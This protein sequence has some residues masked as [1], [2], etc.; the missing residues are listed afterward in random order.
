MHSFWQWDCW[1]HHFF[2]SSSLAFRQFIQ[3]NVGDSSSAASAPAPAASSGYEPEQPALAVFPVSW[4]ILR[5][6]L[7]LGL[8]G[9]WKGP[10]QFFRISWLLRNDM[11]VH[12]KVFFSLCWSFVVQKDVVHCCSTFT[13]RKLG[14][15]EVEVLEQLFLLGNGH[16]FFGSR[17]LRACF[18]NAKQD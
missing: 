17:Y 9:F 5:H 2:D 15:V 10:L 18:E 13:Y 3:K 7:R 6:R 4:H 12:F 1:K 11:F 8:G 14:W 16:R